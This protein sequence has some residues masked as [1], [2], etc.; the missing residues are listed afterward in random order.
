LPAPFLTGYVAIIG[1]PNAG[2]STLLNRLLGQKVVAVAAKPQTTRHKIIGVLT[3][4]GAQIVFVDTPGYHEP[5]K[6]LNQ[7]MVKRALSAL[8]ES[9]T[10]L[11]L[12]DGLFRGEDHARARALALNAPQKLVIAVSKTDLLNKEKLKTLARSLSEEIPDHE[13]WPISAKTGSGLPELLKAIRATLPE[14]PALY[15]EDSLTDQSLR[16]IAAEFIREAAFRLTRLELPYS[17]AVTVDEFIEPDPSDPR[18]L[19]RVSAT[20]HVEKDSQKRIVI[21]SQ[22]RLLKE[23]G[24]QARANIERLTEGQ[25]FLKLFVRVTKDWTKNKKSVAEFGYGDF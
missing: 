24:S 21:G 23:I 16:A 8:A 13:I 2:K 3:D 15:P 5:Q 9:D 19:T 6:L 12:V 25:V 14:G 20:I 1:A 11:W 7:E 10:C 22:G 17:V 4:P 18:R